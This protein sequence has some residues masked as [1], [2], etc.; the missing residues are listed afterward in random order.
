MSSDTLDW[1][2]RI[3]SVLELWEGIPE[4]EPTVAS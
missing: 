3:P 2:E 4:P 1:A